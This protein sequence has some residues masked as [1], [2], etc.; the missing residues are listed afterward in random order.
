MYQIIKNENKIEGLEMKT[1]SDLKFREREH[2]QEWIAGTPSCLGEELLV[3]QKEFSG[4][5]ETNERLDLLALDK[6][7]NLV[8]IENKLDDSGKDVTWQSIKYASYCSTLTKQQIIEIYQDYLGSSAKA[9]EK[10]SEFFDEKE[11]DE[12]VLNQGLNSQR[13]ILIAANFRKE[14]TSTVLWLMNFKI[15]IQCFRVTPFALG[16]QLF[17]NIE[18]ILP[19]KDTEEFSIGIASKAQEE[20]KAQETSNQRELARQKFW[21]QFLHESNQNSN[22]FM[23]NSPSKN[24]WIGKGIGFSGVSL[25]LII[26]QS[27]CR[28]EIYFNCG[29]KKEN[30]DFFDF[31]F[32]MKHQIE[33]D[34][35]SALTWE[36]LDDRTSC[37]IKTQLDGVSY[38]EEADW[39]KMN[40][41]LIASSMNMEKAFKKPIQK[42]KT[43]AK[44]KPSGDSF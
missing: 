5:H 19:I 43:Y 25:N 15:R 12:I 7:G 21:E 30:K 1:F 42:L 20:V 27:N 40:T 31:I 23:N 2:L 39:Q 28:A 44:N 17:L 29:N 14:V 10:I 8:I 9:E 4:F 18:Q 32:K 35:G 22:F 16:S 24:R 34:F 3:I 36:R 11:I 13:L 26:T 6:L 33:K 37:R 41:F 38:L